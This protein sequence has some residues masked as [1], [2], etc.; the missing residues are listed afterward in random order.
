VQGGFEQGGDGVQWPERI[1]PC[2]VAAGCA[3]R[4]DPSGLGCVADHG[5]AVAAVQHTLPLRML[6][7]SALSVS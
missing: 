2:A 4:C 6:P 7:E 1:R 5:D 3:M